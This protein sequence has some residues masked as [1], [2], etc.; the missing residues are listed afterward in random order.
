[1]YG[2]EDRLSGPDAFPIQVAKNFGIPLVFYGENGPFE[3]GNEGATELPIFHPASDDK[4]KVIWLCSIYPYSI[5]DSLNEAR[6]VGFK[7]LDENNHEWDRVGQ[8]ENYTQ[9]DSYGYLVHQWTKYV[10][11]GAQRVADIACRLAREGVL[12]RDQAIYSPIQ[13]IIFVIQGL[14]RDFCHSLGIT[15]EFFDNV[16]EKHVNKDVVDKDI[17]GNWKSKRPFFLTVGNE[18]RRFTTAH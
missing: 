4:T 15:E 9:I 2:F 17:D 12:T 10:K 3:Y 8:I 7:D 1:M 11:F 14:K 13:M 18:K 16:V 5:M 6:E